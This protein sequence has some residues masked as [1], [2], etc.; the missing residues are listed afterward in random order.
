MVCLVQLSCSAARICL[1]LFTSSVTALLCLVQL[2][3]SAAGI[4]L[5][6]FTSTKLLCCAWFNYP[7][8][9][10]LSLP[11]TST[12]T[13][14]LCL[15]QLS[16]SAGFCLHSLTS[17]VTALL[18]LVQLSCSARFG[19]HLFACFTL[20]GSNNFMYMY[21]LCWDWTTSL[22]PLRRCTPTRI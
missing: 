5:H 19:P 14:L 18:C 7:A 21:L 8:L 16:C 10:G 9:L 12:E 15:V 3:C 2:S 1:H 6:P 4:Y 11:L 20:I 17:T 13:A 22:P